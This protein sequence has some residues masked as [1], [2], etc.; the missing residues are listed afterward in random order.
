[1]KR[2]N[3]FLSLTFKK[4][5]KD[6]N[7]VTEAGLFSSSLLKKFSSNSFFWQTLHKGMG[8]WVCVDVN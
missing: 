4:R 2:K 7:V 5:K 8:N 1:M 3:N 6:Q